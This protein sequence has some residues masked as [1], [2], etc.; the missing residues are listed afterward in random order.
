MMAPDVMG[1]RR[2]TARHAQEQ[3]I[4]V[5]RF[6]VAILPPGVTLLRSTKGARRCRC[7][8]PF[9]AAN[10]KGPSAMSLLSAERFPDLSAVPL[11]ILVAELEVRTSCEPDRGLS[12]QVCPRCSTA[13]EEV[14]G[15]YSRVER[16]FTCVTCG[17]RLT[18]SRYETALD[19]YYAE[20]FRVR[21]DQEQLDT[22][23]R[24]LRR[25][26]R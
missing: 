15:S 22:T 16:R 7:A 1:A 23:A 14:F 19:D 24:E 11:E 5:S 2:V 17:L 18:E 9:L 8:S 4:S 20:C 13:A 26:L 3:A 25:A 10:E 21:Q 6:S 12:D